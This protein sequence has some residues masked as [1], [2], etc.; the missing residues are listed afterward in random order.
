MGELVGTAIALAR[1]T[2]GSID[3]S[4]WQSLDALGA[5]Q[6]YQELCRLESRVAALKLGAVRRLET[7]DAARLA[8]ATS[9]GALLAT[10]TDGDRREHE[11]LV[12]TAQGLARAGADA[13]QE[14]LA[15]A[16]LSLRQVEV[17]TDALNA[18]PGGCHRGAA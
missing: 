17:I 11:R 5:Q 15:S 16:N 12:R 14:A 13:A 1:S 4:A 6:A 18:L 3:G 2:L 9:T 10:V 7:L 8:G